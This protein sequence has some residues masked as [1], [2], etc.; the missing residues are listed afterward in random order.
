MIYVQS[1]GCGNFVKVAVQAHIIQGLYNKTF[2]WIVMVVVVVVVVVFDESV[3]I[4]FSDSH[5]ASNYKEYNCAWIW[6]LMSVIW[7]FLCAQ[8]F[9]GWFCYFY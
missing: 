9:G 1:Y 4:L 3:N 2:F 7:P 6:F 8:N 5:A